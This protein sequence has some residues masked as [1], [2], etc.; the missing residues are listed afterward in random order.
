[1]RTGLYFF[2][3]LGSIFAIFTCIKQVNTSKIQPLPVVLISGSP[4]HAVI[5]RGIDT[6]PEGDS[7]RLEWRPSAE[8]EVIGY[9]LYRG[10]HR[11]G[12]YHLVSFIM[13]PDSTYVDETVRIGE[14][15]YYTIRAVTDEHIESDPSDTLDYKLILK[16]I[17]TTPKGQIDEAVPVLG[18]KDPNFP[19]EAFYVIRFKVIHTNT[20]V[21]I[22]RIPS[23]YGERENVRF[24]ADGLASID[25]LHSGTDYQWRV[26]V[27]GS[28]DHMGSES[29]WIQLRYQ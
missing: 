13:I 27:I 20:T 21:W 11:D 18:W 19:P 14:R 12:G 2:L 16:P 28:E 3:L 24:N 1:M 25:M 22:S 8:E 17:D 5:E 29:R 26:D 23:S 6:I 4:D 15:Y 7:I 10:V 9:R